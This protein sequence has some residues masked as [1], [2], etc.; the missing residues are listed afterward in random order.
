MGKPPAG[1]YQGSFHWIGSFDE[2]VAFKAT[3]NLSSRSHDISGK[4]CAAA[5]SVPISALVPGSTAVSTIGF[6]PMP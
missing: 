5:N 2:C 3:Y 4:Y 6:Y 1:L